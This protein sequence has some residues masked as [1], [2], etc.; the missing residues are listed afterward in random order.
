MAA[1]EGDRCCILLYCMFPSSLSDSTNS[2]VIS[3]SAKSM[4]GKLSQKVLGRV[5]PGAYTTKQD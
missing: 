4:I 2:S 5:T 1:N 3:V